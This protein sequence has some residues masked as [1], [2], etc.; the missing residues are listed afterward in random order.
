MAYR[1]LRRPAIARTR[2]DASYRASVL[3]ESC[4]S[5]RRT[6]AAGCVV[7][8]GRQLAPSDL[9]DLRKDQLHQYEPL[10]MTETQTVASG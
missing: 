7:G 6:S 1:R 10:R 3:C 4:T 8:F 9:V 5:D 2:C